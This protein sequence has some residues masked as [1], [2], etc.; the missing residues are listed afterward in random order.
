M[1]D[2][3]PLVPVFALLLA[4]AAPIAACGGAPGR[5]AT[6]VTSTAAP[7][8]LS[9]RDDAGR[10]E[11][12]SERAARAPLTVL[13]FFSSD[14]PV[15]KAHDARVRELVDAYGPRGVAFSAVVSEVGADVAA[16]RAAAKERG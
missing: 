11:P 1:N 14:C 13:L 12:L 15:Q 4:T 6:T 10:D 7:A 5:A 2:K 8:S 9:L 3:L 16:E